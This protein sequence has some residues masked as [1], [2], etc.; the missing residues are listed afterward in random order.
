MAIA[1]FI[2]KFPAVVRPEETQGVSCTIQFNV[3]APMYLTLEN[4]VCTA[5]EGTVSAADLTMQASDEDFIEIFTGKLSGMSAFMS[6]KLV[7][8]GDLSLAQRIGTFF[9]GSKL[10][11]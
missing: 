7:L 9:E 10:A 8:D 3:S 4:G 6:G 5:H 1:D 2:R 11:G